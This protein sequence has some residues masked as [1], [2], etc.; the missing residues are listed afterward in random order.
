MFLMIIHDLEYCS[1]KGEPGEC[2]RFVWGKKKGFI[3]GY[4]SLKVQ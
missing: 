3:F 2:Y 4:G 1:T